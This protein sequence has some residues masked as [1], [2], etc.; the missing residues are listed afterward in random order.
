MSLLFQG[1][2]SIL[3]LLTQ[4]P[5]SRAT[6]LPFLPGTMGQRTVTQQEGQVTV[7]QRHTF[8]TSCT[9]QVSNL[10]GFSWYQ[11]RKGQAPQL[12]SYQAA[13]GPRHSGRLT[14]LLNTTGKYSVL[15]LEEVEVSDSALYLC[16]VGVTLVQGASSAWALAAA[17]GVPRLVGVGEL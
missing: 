2:V 5:P 10:Y 16:A 3:G 7:K 1:F 14:T 4:A 9:Y 8:Q 12:L 11:Q 15:Q 13:A 6:D 17:L